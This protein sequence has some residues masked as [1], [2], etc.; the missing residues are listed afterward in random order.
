MIRPFAIALAL[1]FGSGAFAVLHFSSAP[2]AAPKVPVLITPT[3]RDC[4]QRVSEVPAAAPA[5]AVRA[6]YQREIRDWLGGVQRSQDDALSL[7]TPRTREAWMAA[8]AAPQEIAGPILHSLF[9]WGVPPG[10]EVEL[11]GVELVDNS[12]ASARIRV[13]LRV[14]GAPRPAPGSSTTSPTTKAKA[15]APICCAAP[16]E[17]A[18]AMFGRSQ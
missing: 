8:L 3:C 4:D 10:A 6:L 12:G 7:Y 5:D 15:F 2:L 18:D 1:V 16:L 14:R 13:D 9:G 17:N 11:I